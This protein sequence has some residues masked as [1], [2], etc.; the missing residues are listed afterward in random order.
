MVRGVV[1]T[2]EAITA[3]SQGKWWNENDGRWTLTDLNQE[4]KWLKMQPEDNDDILGDIRKAWKDPSETNDEKEVKD[5]YYYDLLEV[6]PSADEST[7]KRQYYVLARRY[8]PDRA[9]QS[10]DAKT[11]FREIGTAYVVLSNH[12]FRERYDKY[13]VDFMYVDDEIAAL[14]DRKPMV[15]PMVMYRMLFGSDKFVEYIGTLAAATSAS[16]GD[17]PRVTKAQARLLQKR[18][19]TR[20][21]LLLA[22]RL[23]DYT[24]DKVAIAKAYWKTEAEYLSKASYGT[25]LTNTIGKVRRRHVLCRFLQFLGSICSNQH[26]LLH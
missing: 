7:I 1:N 13:G 20:L 2:P 24:E 19:V 5:A 11:K 17:D 6:S 21:A 15:D 10:E 8:S 4:R 25:E 12:D 18:R 16:V 26:F 14:E 3:P 23:K 22:E 9:G